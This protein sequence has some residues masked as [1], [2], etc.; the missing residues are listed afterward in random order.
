ST[1]LLGVPPLSISPARIP[2]PV[3]G[4]RRVDGW[5]CCDEALAFRRRTHDFDRSDAASIEP[6]AG[7]GCAAWPHTVHLRA[8]SG[9]ESN[10][11]GFW[12]SR[13]VVHF[14]RTVQGRRSA[15]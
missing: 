14:V 15:M 12:F 5:G 2:E 6:N 1:L 7:V 10:R 3:T 11:A 4:S 9:R 8:L 13:N